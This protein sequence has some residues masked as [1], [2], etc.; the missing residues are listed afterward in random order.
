[1][2]HLKWTTHADLAIRRVPTVGREEFLD[3]MTFR[4]NELGVQ[5]TFC[6]FPSIPISLVA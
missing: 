5:H 6:N 2:P 4:R 1:M 3:H